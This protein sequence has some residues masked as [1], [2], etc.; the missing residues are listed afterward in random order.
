MW[1]LRTDFCEVQGSTMT[2]KA[3]PRPGKTLFFLLSR[4][5]KLGFQTHVKPHEFA[6]STSCMKLTYQRP[7]PRGARCP[8]QPCSTVPYASWSPTP[9]AIMASSF[10]VRTTPADSTK[11]RLNGWEWQTQVIASVLRFWET[12]CI[13]PS[14]LSSFPFLHQY[15]EWNL[16]SSASLVNSLPSSPG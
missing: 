10:P 8:Y 13:P 14:L 2:S 16:Q 15:W 6:G 7:L 12:E 11:A 5:L 1:L 9:S 3:T 4:K